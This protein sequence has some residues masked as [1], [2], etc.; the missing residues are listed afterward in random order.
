MIIFATVFNSFRQ[1]G[2][3][4]IV[5]K[6]RECFADGRNISDN[7]CRD[8]L[9]NE[10]HDR[11]MEAN[12]EIPKNRRFID[13]SLLFHRFIVTENF[14][15]VVGRT[16][17]LLRNEFFPLFNVCLMNQC[18]FGNFTLSPLYKQ[19]HTGVYRKKP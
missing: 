18:I 1:C 7:D 10:L 12:Q 19:P 4:K 14:L 5:G 9:P 8:P 2:D 17:S 16:H 3:N 13:S 6:S 15:A 11:R